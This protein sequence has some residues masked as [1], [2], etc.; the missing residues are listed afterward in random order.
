M[1][2]ARRSSWVS[3]G[4]A[5][6]VL[7]AAG[8]AFSPS[9]ARAG[10]TGSPPSPVACGS[11]TTYTAW[12]SAGNSDF[13]YLSG[14]QSGTIEV[15]VRNAK[16]GAPS[17]IDFTVDASPSSDVTLTGGPYSHLDVGN[18]GAFNDAFAAGNELGD[19]VVRVRARNG[20]NNPVPQY[21]VRCTPG[22]VTLP[23][24]VTEWRM[25]EA[26]W[27][28][29]AADVADQGGGYPG[30]STNGPTTDDADPA[31][32][33]DP[34]TCRYGRFDGSDDYVALPGFPDLTRDFTITAWIRSTTASGD[35]R[36]FA[37]DQNN[38]RGY[39]L[40][41]GDG[42]DGR[43]RF[44][45]RGVNPVS[46]DS[47]AVITPDTWHHV[48]AV[49]D[50]AART[51]EIWVDGALVASD[52][53]S[54]NWRTDT[55]LASIGGEVDG[56]SEGVPNWRFGGSLDEVRVYDA[57]LSG[58]QIQAV[59]TDWHACPQPN[60][61]HFEIA[62]D[63]FGIHCADETIDVTAA[64]A[65]GAPVTD[66]TGTIELDTQT[67][68]GS[69]TSAPGN[70]GVLVDA[71][72]D[73]GRAR[74]TF[75]D[76]DDG[77]A[78]F[79][80]SYPEG[81]TPLNLLVW[82]VAAPVVQDDDSEGL[83]AWGASGF[84]V[85]ASA[86]ANPPPSPINDPIPTQTA[87]QAFDLHLAAYGVTADDPTCGVIESYA[88]TKG[89][90]FWSSYDDPSSGSIAV[91]VDG[92]GIATNEGASAPQNVSFSNGQAVVSGKYKDVG[93]IQVS[94]K[95]DGPAEPV[96]GIRGA[97]N[98]FVVQPA[99]FVIT[100]IQRPDLSANPGI[101]VP[102]GEVFVAA[103]APF[104]VTVEV[105]DAEGDRT[106]NYGNES[107]A[108]GIG[109]TAPT[110]VAPVGGRN[111]SNDDGAIGNG[112]AFTAVPPAGTF[113]NTTAYWDEVGAITLQASV[114][115]ASY[116]GTGDVTGT[117]SGTVGRFRVDH[118]GVSL[119]APTFD[120][121]CA[122]GG[123][124]YVGQPFVY[125]VGGEPIITATAQAVGNTT[126]RNYTGGWFRLTNASLGSR[127]YAAATGTLD[128]LGLPSAASDPAIVDVG[129]GTATLT[130]SA[131]SGISFQRGLT[132]VAPFFAD[133]A[134][135]LDV[136][137]LDG[138]A[139]AANPA[140]FGQAVAGL[141]IP[142]DSG[143]EMRWGRLAF[144]NAHGSELTPLLVPLRAEHFLAAGY[145]GTN[146]ADSC[147]LLSVG[148]LQLT[149][150]PV[151]LSST[152]TL[153]NVP[154]AAGDA[155]LSL[156]APGDGNTGTI[157]LLQDLSATGD[158]LIWLRFDWDQDGSHDDD[159]TGRATFG[160]FSGDGS[161]IFQREV[162]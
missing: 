21:R 135:S 36:V 97:S 114:A 92:N 122:A 134:L 74:Y 72:T 91:T 93:R 154:L 107:T 26:S 13:I 138:A 55:G 105:R 132:P 46:L 78:S 15:E 119:N 149:P 38:S 17:D 136:I 127:T 139:Y 104:R 47:G 56:G 9:S 100:A 142:F 98:L 50:R 130:F 102:G 24:P 3:G 23:T 85:T 101:S 28:A 60:A 59:M 1:S 41:L 150:T 103:G 71:V 141:G 112:S 80:L 129:N 148:N 161:V 89:L 8:Q 62:H 12:Q 45:A 88:G 18:G 79:F 68:R 43:L 32:A 116:L 57:A 7:V 16:S 123:F 64:S 19:A 40:S 65:G 2:R 83:L 53:Y 143:N 84:T 42:G 48:A 77:V 34:G 67:G 109:L 118:F 6:L 111:G 120:T 160:V 10:D 140:R 156:S 37:D 131:G 159:P 125:M 133:L 61:D 73:D 90:K 157:D 29:G 153:G 108:E 27:G 86:L 76:A 11:I 20:N 113:E 52:T 117:E 115:D 124:G 152:P 25:E 39:A 44:F 14:S 96:A 94:M 5:V 145:F 4:W 31:V 99:D 151:T 82:D 63:G 81:S 155:G 110:L 162:Y 69:W 121:P 147:T 95:D 33:G 146:G 144:Q 70:A 51:R 128:L 75:A 87:G 158:D 66:Y 30:T 106:P 58:G 126:T 49:H 54:S 137:D 22:A 35:Q